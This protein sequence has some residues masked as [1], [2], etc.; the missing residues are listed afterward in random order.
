MQ[1]H[2]DIGSISEGTLKTEDIGN[3]LI[4]HMDRLDLDNTDLVL[5]KK[6]KKEFSEEIEH[7]EESEEE[8]SE[9]LENIFD[10][11]KEIADN[12]T[13]DYC[14]LR[15]HENDGADFGVWV[16][17]ELFEDTRQGSYDG[18]V[19]RSTV[20]TNGVDEPVPEEYSH[21]LAVNDHGNC[22]LW[23]RDG[24]SWKECWAIV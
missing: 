2:F 16:V 22:T 1:T 18:M 21:Y 11:I 7:L 5:F 19:Y 23:S 20:H 14:Y 10:E 9:K 24:D 17:S 3:N 15:M 4:W 6:L 12:Y 13:P 8:Y